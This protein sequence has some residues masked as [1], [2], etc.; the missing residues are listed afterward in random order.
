M[1]IL[2]TQEEKQIFN[3]LTQEQKK[4]YMNGKLTE[5]E[6]LLLK[7]IVVSN[8][9][10][11]CFDDLEK[12]NM[13]RQKLKQVGKNYNTHLEKLINQVF[14]ENERSLESTDY[15]FNMTNRINLSI[16]EI[17]NQ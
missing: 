2:L 3:N 12:Y 7:T 15:V 14:D 13:H 16:S 10:M 1:E 5:R 4:E 17:I 11:E 6:N 8:V 9:L